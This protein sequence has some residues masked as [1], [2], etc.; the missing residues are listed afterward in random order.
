M[1]DDVFSEVEVLLERLVF[2][3]VIWLDELVD[4]LGELE[5]LEEDVLDKRLEKA[6]DLELELLKLVPEE[7]EDEVDE[8]EDILDFKQDSVLVEL[9]EILDCLLVELELLNEV[10]DIEDFSEKDWLVQDD[11]SIEDVL[12]DD[13]DDKVDFDDIVLEED[14]EWLEKLDCVLEVDFE[15]LDSILEE[16]EEL[17]LLL[18]IFLLVELV[19]E[20][21]KHEVEI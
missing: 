12:E 5:V 4:W 15:R 9:L 18:D 19:E 6:Q 7:G 11:D 17:E 3:E 10:L 21:E 16:Q 13:D 2:C 8:H 20:V 1:V 14:V